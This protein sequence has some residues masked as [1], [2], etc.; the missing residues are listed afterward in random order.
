MLICLRAPMLL[1]Y[2][3]SEVL[4]LQSEAEREGRRERQ[5]VRHLAGPERVTY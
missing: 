2:S 3:F 5:D 4:G 1:S